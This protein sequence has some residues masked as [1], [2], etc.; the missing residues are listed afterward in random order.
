MAALRG[1]LERIGVATVSI[2]AGA[3]IA[4]FLWTV[5]ELTSS[6]GLRILLSAISIGVLAACSLAAILAWRWPKDPG[7]RVLA[8]ALAFG[9]FFWG[10]FVLTAAMLPLDSPHRY[11][12][13]NLGILGQGLLLLEH[14]SLW[15]ALAALI[16]FSTL[17][18]RVLTPADYVISEEGDSY[19]GGVDLESRLARQI[20]RLAGYFITRVA[21]LRVL[22][23]RAGPSVLSHD[24]GDWWVR[25]YAWSLNRP[26][27][28]ALALL[29][30]VGLGFFITADRSSDLL[31]IGELAATVACMV[32]YLN[33]R[34]NYGLSDPGLQRQLVWIAN[35][36]W[37][38]LVLPFWAVV[39]FLRVP[40][41]AQLFVEIED[42]LGAWGLIILMLSGGGALF[43]VFLSVAVFYSGALDPRLVIRT[44]TLYGLLG[45]ILIF[46]FGAVEITISNLLTERMALPEGTGAWIAGGTI[47]MAFGP[48]R[49]RIKAATDRFLGER[50]PP[51]VL[52][53]APTGEAVVVFSD[54]VGYTAL[55]AEDRK[56]A[57]TLVSVFH[58]SA[59]RVV[60][61]HR[62]RLVK[63]IGDAVLMEF[64]D[65]GMALEAVLDLHASFPRACDLLDLPQTQLRT[66]VHYGE[67]SRAPDGD[68]FG[69]TV[70]LASRL[71]TEG[72]PGEVIVSGGLVQYESI[73][74]QFTFE[75]LGHR[76]LKNV[77]G[78]VECYRLIA[79]TANGC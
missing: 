52:A 22:L 29:F 9:A 12:A 33:F 24:L 48:L 66:G 54:L 30:G 47:A 60:N 18:P 53:E 14:G 13:A 50:L 37:L 40:I 78:P 74:D 62:G 7:Q 5:D 42:V 63:S 2:L 73:R 21:H 3:D 20:H 31:I 38:G 58:K 16:Q 8:S 68:L 27:V 65:A 10:A 79:P 15:F 44:T 49:S 34:V 71:Q 51:T 72:Q 61:K 45:S 28:W 36:A 69:E 19:L 32:S 17:F 39:I 75:N 11:L 26:L 6:A 76:Q 55:T 25:I 35:G 59:R 23:P 56:A 57:L 46:L 41:G 64:L 67:V 4:F 1:I 77:P 70:N 43:A